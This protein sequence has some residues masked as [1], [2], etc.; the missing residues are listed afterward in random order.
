MTLAIATTRISSLKH[1]GDLCHLSRLLLLVFVAATASMQ[2][3]KADDTLQGYTRQYETEYREFLKVRSQRDNSPPDSEERQEFI[4]Q[5]FIMQRG[6]D[7]L[8][9]AITELGG[10]VKA[11]EKQVNSGGKTDGLK[12]SPDGDIELGIEDTQEK[13]KPP[14]DYAP[15]SINNWPQDARSMSDNNRLF[16]VLR[17]LDEYQTEWASKNRRLFETM[18]MATRWEYYLEVVKDTY[19]KLYNITFEVQALSKPDLKKDAKRFTQ[20]FAENKAFAKTLLNNTLD[21]Y[22]YTTKSKGDNWRWLELGLHSSGLHKKY[23]QAQIELRRL[24]LTEYANWDQALY[25]AWEGEVSGKVAEIIAIERQMIWLLGYGQH[26]NKL[27]QLEKLYRQKL[28][29]LPP[30]QKKMVNDYIALKFFER[31]AEF[32]SITPYSSPK[33]GVDKEEG[34]KVNKNN[35]QKF[36]KSLA[37]TDKKISKLVDDLRKAIQRIGGRDAIMKTGIERALKLGLFKPHRAN[38]TGDTFYKDI[39]GTARYKK[40]KKI[41]PVLRQHSVYTEFIHK[42]E[43]KRFSKQSSLRR[44]LVRPR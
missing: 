44:R 23:E 6:L 35:Q 1:T 37:A 31:E 24:L 34:E 14:E 42:Q 20:G 16:I 12:V 5:M 32:L 29:I 28:E 10:D 25:S 4:D 33:G 38:K 40:L 26:R 27:K 22:T 13:F 18:D 7:F 43:M 11:I 39:L 30:L 3:T 17:T 41:L 21:K 9:S 19:E 15:W 2:T 36:R 8:K